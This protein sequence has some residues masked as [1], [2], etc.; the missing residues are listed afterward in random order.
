MQG[1]QLAAEKVEFTHQFYR[2]RYPAI[3]KFT[4]EEH[5]GC[6]AYEYHPER[7]AVHL[8]FSNQGT[9]IYGPLSHHRVDVRASELPTGYA[10]R[11]AFQPEV[12]LVAHHVGIGWLVR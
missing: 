1:L 7:R 3:P 8:H 10:T 6:F 2:E 4:D 11:G 12:A 9:S 5:W